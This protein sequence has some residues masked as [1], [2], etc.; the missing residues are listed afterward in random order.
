MIPLKFTWEGKTYTA[1]PAPYVKASGVQL[2]VVKTDEAGNAEVKPD[3]K[4][5]VQVSEATEAAETSDAPKEAPN[6]L[7]ALSE[8]A[9]FSEWQKRN[10]ANDEAQAVAKGAAAELLE[11][12]SVIAARLVSAGKNA[13]ALLP[14]GVRVKARQTKDGPRLARPGEQRVVSLDPTAPPSAN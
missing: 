10:K 7:A 12:E 6:G 1:E 8:A 5:G 11:V 14:G 2:K 13:V 9:L 4:R 3:G